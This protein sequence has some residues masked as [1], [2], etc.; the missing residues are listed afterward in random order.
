MFPGRQAVI[1]VHGCFL[2]S[3]DWHL[4]NWPKTRREFW[5][6]KIL[7]NARN[8]VRHLD[9]LREDGW[10]VLVKRECALKGKT[11]L[12]EGEPV[13]RAAD[14]LDSDSQFSESHGSE[15]VETKAH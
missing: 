15:S 4:F 3:H 5:G 14:W 1:F 7:A 13:S 12:L 9:A 8:D 11:K 10:R 2:R 6:N